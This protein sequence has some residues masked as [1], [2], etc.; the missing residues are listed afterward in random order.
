VFSTLRTLTRFSFQIT[1]VIAATIWPELSTAYGAQQWPV[2]RKLHRY[3]C[4]ASLCFS[5]VSSTALLFSG[6]WIVRVWTH[7]GVTFDATVFRILLVVIVAN[8][9]WYT[10]SVV[11]MAAN[12][13]ERLALFYLVGA[14]GSLGIADMLLPH[15]GLSGAALAL[16]FFELVTGLYTVRRSL[17]MLDDS[18]GEFARAIFTPPVFSASQLRLAFR[19]RPVGA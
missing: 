19:R 6:E 2:A 12:R 7:G 4:Q 8:S 13:H 16:L 18:F 15:S 3:A 9:L 17:S 1:T 14:A 10:S 5:V 11:P